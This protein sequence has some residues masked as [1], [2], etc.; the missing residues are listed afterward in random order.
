MGRL[1][2]SC[3]NAAMQRILLDDSGGRNDG[4]GTSGSAMLLQYGHPSRKGG[5]GHIVIWI[6]DE[7]GQFVRPF[8]PL[9]GQRIDHRL[10][11]FGTPGSHRRRHQSGKRHDG[12]SVLDSIQKR[13]VLRI[14]T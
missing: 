13:P 9:V 5:L 11:H 4:S 6:G 8:T 3:V 7:I 14:Q 10:S 2:V 12:F 1:H